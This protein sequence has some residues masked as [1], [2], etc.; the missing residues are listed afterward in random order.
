MRSGS[1]RSSRC[2]S[3]GPDRSASEQISGLQQAVVIEP[4]TATALL[5]SSKPNGSGAPL[6]KATLARL[7]WRGLSTPRGTAE[8]SELPALVNPR[9]R[10]SSTPQIGE[11]RMDRRE[12]NKAIG[13]A[14]AGMVAGS[15]V[16]SRGQGKKGSKKDDKA[17]KHVCKGK[18]DCKGQGADG[19]NDCKG[20]GSCATL[21]HDCKG[22]NACK[23]QGGC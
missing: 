13:A 9:E 14:V 16:F 21:K 18:N 6:S 22:K 5:G 4:W 12:F 11:E 15:A 10:E 1:P 2:S 7:G 17:A 8:S 20:T 23:G 19:K 3:Y